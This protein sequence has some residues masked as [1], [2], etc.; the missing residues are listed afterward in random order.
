MRFAQS[1]PSFSSLFFGGERTRDG[2]AVDRSVTESF[3]WLTEIHLFRLGDVALALGAPAVA[4]ARNANCYVK[5][6]A[7]VRGRLSAVQ[8][9]R[10]EDRHMW[11]HVCG[12]MARMGVHMLD[13]MFANHAGRR[14]QPHFP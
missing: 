8:R 7:L 13:L 3:G 4:N 5:L 12:V 14:P 11:R 2:K 9:K 1:E 6:K 10:V